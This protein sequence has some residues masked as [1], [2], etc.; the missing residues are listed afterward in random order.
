MTEL[1]ESYA[2][3]RFARLSDAELLAV[4]G[5]DREDYTERALELAQIEL[6]RRGVS[7]A[8]PGMAAQPEVVFAAKKI[9]AAAA[10][11]GVVWL[12]IYTALVGMA[13]VGTPMAMLVLD[14]PSS[15][16]LLPQI[17]ISAFQ[18]AVAYGL[19]KRRAWGWY[20]NWVLL[21][22]TLGLPGSGG[23][24]GAVGRLVMVALNGVYFAKRRA[25]FE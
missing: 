2:A 24:L 9:R 5:K 16:D 4:V 12:G 10:P 3:E 25:L 15:P 21:A 20:L 14:G 23:A 18:C 17:P 11:L 13:A 22:V 6:D 19:S 1:S 7:G 8:E